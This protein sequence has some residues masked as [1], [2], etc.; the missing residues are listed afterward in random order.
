MARGWWKSLWVRKGREG[1]ILVDDVNEIVSVHNV[2]YE[3]PCWRIM[4]VALGPV[5]SQPIS[6]ILQ[7]SVRWRRASITFHAKKDTVSTMVG[8]IISFPGNTPQVTALGPSLYVFVL[9]SPCLLTAWN[10]IF[11]SSSMT[12]R[13]GSSAWGGQKHSKYAFW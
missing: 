11:W 3:L 8:W 9:R 5:I 1:R 2:F 10:V 6:L 4:I 7:Q 13:S 12:A